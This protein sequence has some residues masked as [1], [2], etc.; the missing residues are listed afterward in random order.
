MTMIKGASDGNWGVGMQGSDL[1]RFPPEPRN[2]TFGQW[3]RAAL[4]SASSIGGAVLG[5]ATGVGSGASGMGDFQSLLNT[6]M[7]V[8]R[9]MAM[10]SMESNISK[11]R[12]ET[13]MAPIRNLR[14]G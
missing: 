11:S 6:Q 7:E 5:V 14:V 8:Q 10:V 1:V 4:T 2:S 12:H 3:G 13:E 9:V